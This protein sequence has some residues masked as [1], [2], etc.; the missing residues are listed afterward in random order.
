MAS[1]DVIHGVAAFLTGITQRRIQKQQFKLLQQ[2]QEQERERKREEFEFMRQAQ[3]KDFQ[4]EKKFIAD[5]KQSEFQEKLL[6]GQA[7]KKQAPLTRAEK[8][9]EN[10]L[11]IEAEFDLLNEL[12]GPEEPLS[13]LQI[14][15]GVAAGDIFEEHG[16]SEIERITG[17][18][19]DL[20]TPSVD[21]TDQE[22]A[23]KFLVGKALEGGF[24]PTAE[25]LQTIQEKI[26]GGI[27]IGFE[28]QPPPIDPRSIFPPLD[29]V[30][31][32]D[33]PI[34]VDTTPAPKDKTTVDG[35]TIEFSPVE[36]AQAAEDAAK[37]VA[38]NDTTGFNSEEMGQFE[39]LAKEQTVLFAQWQSLSDSDKRGSKGDAKL[40]QLISNEKQVRDL[41]TSSQKR[42]PVKALKTP[43]ERISQVADAT[44]EFVAKIGTVVGIKGN[45]RPYSESDMEK[46]IE[47]LIERDI[48]GAERQEIFKVFTANVDLFVPSRTAAEKLNVSEDEDD[49]PKRYIP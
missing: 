24:L 8:R 15:K 36:K 46:D 19:M 11:D 26:T 49:I 21:L 1:K 30:P 13:V 17:N 35:I 44:L 4:R 2:Q 47:K 7:V 12:E 32:V 43:E 14:I 9:T 45:R 6:T 28:E 22:E 16:E 38:L 25:T 5:L 23:A 18:F 39:T 10:L 20:P 33:A 41:Q 31:T 40:R 3:F 42:R 37:S 27:E 34:T 29:G 48:D